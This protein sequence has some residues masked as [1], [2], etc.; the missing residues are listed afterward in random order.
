M[1][2]KHFYLS[3]LLLATVIIT[4]GCGKKP[5]AQ[6]VPVNNPANNQ[7]QE[8][9]QTQ[10][11]GQNQEPSQASNQEKG[12]TS[13]SGQYS[14]N[15]LFALNRPMKCSWKESAAGDGAVSNVI[16]LNNKNFYQDVTMDDIG[17]SFMIF[18]GEYLYLW[19]DFNDAASKM[20]NTQTKTGIEPNKDSA[21]LDQKKDFVCEDWVADNSFFTP[22]Q[23]RDF[24]DVTEEMNQAVK[25]MG[26]GGLEKTKQQACDLCKSAPSQELREKCMGD[27]KCD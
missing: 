16:Y 12:I 18:N 5:D 27:M 10:V 20:K 26:E 4:S 6:P 23:D 11:Q 25:E 24:K 3:V 17:H 14:I 7:N 21:G 19:N 8:Q 15:E 1:P 9:N 2:Q 22:P 13:P